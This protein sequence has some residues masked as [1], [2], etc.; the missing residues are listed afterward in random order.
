[1][2]SVIYKVVKVGAA[3]CHGTGVRGGRVGA[4]EGFDTEPAA[5]YKPALRLFVA[6]IGFLFLCV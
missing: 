2:E 1:M 5:C 4:G 3:I 6:C